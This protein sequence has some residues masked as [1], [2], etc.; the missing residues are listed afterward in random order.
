MDNDIGGSVPPPLVTAASLS[1]VEGV[2]LLALAVL[3]LADV[4]GG[5]LTMGLTTAVFFAAFGGLLLVSAWLITHGQTWPRG[6]ILLAQLI[7]LGLAWNMRTGE[8][9]VLA[10]G[11]AVVAL[12]VIAGLLHPTSIEAL[13]PD[14]RS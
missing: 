14:S 9:V 11:L 7:A 2:L 5:R 8:T 3:E 1:A 4:T 13:D 6:P 10:A 12:I